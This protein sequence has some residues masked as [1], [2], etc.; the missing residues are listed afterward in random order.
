MYGESNMETYVTLCKMIVNE[1]L[2]HVS[3]NSNTVFISKEWD[4]EDV[5]EVQKGGY[6][7]IPITNSWCDLTENSKIL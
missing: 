3:G 6:T 7:C 1:L 2:L 5:R 4:D